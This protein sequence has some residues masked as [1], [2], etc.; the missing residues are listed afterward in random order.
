[1]K[2]LL[3]IFCLLSIIM[4]CESERTFSIN[5]SSENDDIDSIYIHELSKELL[6]VKAGINQAN[7][8]PINAK[9]SYTTIGNIKTKDEKKAI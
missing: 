9:V 3:L 6:M 5:I 4:A 1:M 2:N 8:K 7:A